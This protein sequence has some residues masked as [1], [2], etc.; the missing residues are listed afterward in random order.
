MKTN[1]GAF[2]SFVFSSHLRGS[3]F[4]N[5]PPNFG[6]EKNF[7]QTL[8]SELSSD[9]SKGTPPLIVR[10]TFNRFVGAAKLR[11]TFKRCDNHKLQNL[12]ILAFKNYQ[13]DKN[14]IT[15]SMFT[16]LLKP[17]TS[18][19]VILNSTWILLNRYVKRHTNLRIPCAL[20]LP[21]PQ[22]FWVKNSTSE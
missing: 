22:E 19:K 16:G 17:P 11:R 8:P 6:S 1:A 13:R 9:V 5:S 21:L 15:I 14:T 7:P 4:K 2:C 3:F 18:G 10:K 12:T 20:C